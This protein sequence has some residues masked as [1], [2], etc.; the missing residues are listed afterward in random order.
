MEFQGL[1]L[2][3]IRELRQLTIEALGEIVGVKKTAISQFE[4]GKTNPS[5]ET[6]NKL[7]L[8]LR[9]PRTFFFTERRTFS[10]G[11]IYF[12][13]LH[14]STKT[15]QKLAKRRLEWTE[16]IVEYL[17]KYLQ[18]I[19]VN[20]LN[21]PKT[22][23]QVIDESKIETLADET[24]KLYGLG[25]YPIKNL[26]E[27]LEDNG[28][29][30]TRFPLSC[31]TQDALSMWGSN[32]SRPYILLNDDKQ[33]AVRSRLDLAHE[34]GHLI[35]HQSVNEESLKNSSL[36][37]MIEK[38][39]FRFGSALMLPATSFV[40]DIRKGKISLDRLVDLKDKWKVSV[41][42]MIMRLSD[43]E[44]IR[45]DFARKLWMS[46]NRRGWKKSEPLDDII[47]VERPKIIEN[48]FAVLQTNKMLDLSEIYNWFNLYP[49]EIEQMAQIP[50]GF[51]SGG[52]D[53]IDKRL[54]I[55]GGLSEVG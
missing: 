2:R 18:L 34:L 47:P 22:N 51:L 24:R 12:R 46:Y 36:F 17:T 15:A 40:N 38:Q 49:Y 52:S 27:V 29:I 43:L 1:R 23:F 6:V 4:L 28:F 8:V 9:V 41:G 30:V 33:C 11:A 39:A 45:E 42:A 55:R 10:H 32:N 5:T 26:I 19:E 50:E 31:V 35:M 7:S 16:E 25:D 37:P 13:S 3:E 20:I 48:A 54:I 14:S 44:I 53:P 21:I